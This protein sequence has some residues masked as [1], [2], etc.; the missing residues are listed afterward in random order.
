M[1]NW[2]V[3]DS[4]TRYLRASHLTKERDARAA[5]AVMKKAL[6][7]SDAPP[8]TITTDK[9]RSYIA[10]IKR[11]FPDARHIQSDGIRAKVNN[12]R[13]ERV[14]GTFRQRTK[15]LRGLENRETG[16]RYL[17]GWVVDY[18]LFRDHEALGGK[19]PGEAAKVGSP[20]REWADVTRGRIR[21]KGDTTDAPRRRPRVLVVPSIQPKDRNRRPPVFGKTAEYKARPHHRTTKQQSRGGHD[22]RLV[23]PRS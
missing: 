15:T 12:N 6:A 22:R 23:G 16:Q 1:W 13:S 3:M 10:P 7:A 2:N 17:D 14:Q 11:V 8:K 5:E 18:N 19:T 21:P 9:L 4:D 20:F